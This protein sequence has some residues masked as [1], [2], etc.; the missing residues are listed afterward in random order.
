MEADVLWQD[1]IVLVP[2]LG[3]V[4]IALREIRRAKCESTG[5][6]TECSVMTLA[7]VK[8]LPSMLGGSDASVMWGQSGFV[9][10]IS[11]TSF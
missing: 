1:V 3:D 10:N 6:G 4:R 2:D 9:S 8:K 5:C 11:A 7:S